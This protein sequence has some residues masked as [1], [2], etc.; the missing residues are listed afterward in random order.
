[1]LSPA[2]PLANERPAK[3]APFLAETSFRLSATYDRARLSLYRDKG[4]RGHLIFVASTASLTLLRYED[5]GYFNRVYALDNDA[6]GRLE[7]I[8]GFFKGSPH[9]CRLVTPNLSPTGALARACESRGWLP[10]QEYAWLA[11]TD[12]SPRLNGP[13]DFEIRPP[14]RDERQLFLYSYLAAFGADPAGHLL[15]VEN[16]RHLF[17]LPNLHF[18]LALQ[19]GRPAGIGMM[20]RAGTSALLCAGAT[21]PSHS[22]QGCHEALLAARIRLAHELGCT[23]VHAWAFAGSQSQTNMESVGLRTV[24]TTRAWRFPPDRVA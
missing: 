13:A 2:Q 23:S 18:L 1:M 16:M 20:Y 5:V 3:S 14:R 19:D 11:A 12:L 24:S 7:S 15:A 10:D 8:E 17:S 21:L 9:G 4:S 6:A 22:G